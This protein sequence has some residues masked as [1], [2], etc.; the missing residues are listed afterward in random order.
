MDTLF[1]DLRYTVRTLARAPGFALVAVLTLALGIGANT[2]VFS[3][4]NAILL[5]PPAHVEAPERLVSVYTSDFSGPAFGASSYPDVVEFGRQAN[6]FEGVAAF[7]VRPAGV[8]AVEDPEPALA[9]AVTG[10][11]F[12]VMGVRPLRGRFF[13]PEEARVPG[14]AQVAVIS[15]RLWERRFGRAPDALGKP[16]LVSGRPFTVVGVMPAGFDGGFRGLALDV[17]VPLTASP[18]LGETEVE[19]RGHRGLFVVGRLR[20]GVTLD[21]ARERMAVVARRLAAEDPDMWND[22]SGAARRITLLPERE[23]RVPPQIRGPVL[24]FAGLLTAVVGIVLLICCANLAGLMLARASARRREVGI[25]LSLGAS[26][27]RIVRQMLTESTLL[28]LLGGAAGVLLSIWAAELMVGARL[29]IPVQVALDLRPDLTVLAFTAAIAVVTGVVFGLAPALQASRPDLVGAL[30]SETAV[31][32][33]ARRRV[34]LRSA[35][36]VSQVAMSLLLLIGA[37][38]FLRAL[39]SAAA[40]D[41]GFRAEHLLV[42][43]LEPRPGTEEGDPAASLAAVQ[44]ARRRVAALP[45][46]RAATWGSSVPLAGASRRWISVEGYQPRQGEDMEFH[47]NMVGPD[48]FET[49]GIGLARGRGL[50]EADRAGAPG[51]VV[52]SETFA[53]RFWPGQDAVGKR[54]GT[55]DRPYT[56]VGVARDARHVSLT[57]APRPYVYYAALQEPQ[58]VNLMV[59]TDG[60]PR[61]AASAVAAAVRE[62]APQFTV[63][64]PRPMEQ[65]LGAALLPQ[66]IVS[67]A[68]GGFALL[69][70]AL[71]SMGLYGVVAYAV[72]RRTREIGV[73]IALGA[74]TRDV[75]RLVVGQGARLAAAGVVLGLAGAWAL[76]RLL[77]GLLLGFS[78]TDPVT[79]LG[80]PL[81]LAGVALLASWLPARRAARV[82]PMTALRAE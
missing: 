45:G 42:A 19:Q 38:L 13:A 18:E 55:G 65:V 51:V 50:T 15:E 11:F 76:T 56:V 66:R 28:A 82:D 40:I 7:T 43:P 31:L 52:V 63:R 29:P 4:V 6:V 17:W 48:Y 16:L 23:S 53:R 9:Q 77:S 71:A 26:R 67:R 10:E 57:D 3:L 34:S 36:V 35:L 49:L 27:R 22:L 5:R 24:G 58:G 74:R 69:A 64:N 47:Y 21:A 14:G 8:G 30:K 12:G 79:F 60:D 1:Q 73:R 70:L 81:L 2:T 41:T 39:G 46:V 33:G 37:T 59:R 80:A 61:Q 32:P 62:A 75:L 44:E 68:L 20:D 54:I 78:P 25:R 72:A